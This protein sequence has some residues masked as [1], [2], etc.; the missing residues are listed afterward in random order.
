MRLDLHGVKH[1]DVDRMVENFIYLNQDAVPLTI[2]CGN[3]QAMI[4]LVMT[5]TTRI[6]CDTME[7]QYGTIVVNNV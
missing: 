7:L 2:I 3:S 5:V 4:Q 6:G 1:Q